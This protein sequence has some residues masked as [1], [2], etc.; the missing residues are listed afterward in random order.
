MLEQLSK[1]KDLVEPHATN[2]TPWSFTETDAVYKGHP[3][4]FNAEDDK[5]REARKIALGE[6]IDAGLPK[7]V[8]RNICAEGLPSSLLQLKDITE[9]LKE[10]K[11]KQETAQ[12]KAGSVVFAWGFCFG[13]LYC[14]GLAYWWS[15]SMQTMKWPFGNVV[16]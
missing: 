3:G 11:E 12:W 2:Y 7:R 6:I 13:G 10:H 8:A 16:V 5:I 1:A 9:V 4:G 15:P 14:C